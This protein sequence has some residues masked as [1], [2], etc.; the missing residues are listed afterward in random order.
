MKKKI[1]F[2]LRLSVFVLLALSLKVASAQPKIDKKE[3][4]MLSYFRQRYPTRIEINAKG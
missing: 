2:I 3:T 1:I 4:W